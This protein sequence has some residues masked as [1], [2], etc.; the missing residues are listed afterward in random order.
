M[1]CTFTDLLAERA[2]AGRGLGACTCYDLETARGVLAAADERGAG[3]VLLVSAAA[4]ADAGGE[5]L[6]AGLVAAAERAPARACVQANM[7]D[8][9]HLVEIMVTACR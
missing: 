7:A 4:F 5:L 1:L 3:V 8:P 6:L 9:R 2:A